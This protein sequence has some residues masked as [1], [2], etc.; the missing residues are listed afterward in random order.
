MGRAERRTFS[1][2]ELA[3]CGGLTGYEGREVPASLLRSGR[4]PMQDDHTSR[5]GGPEADGLQQPRAACDTEGG[6]LD[7]SAGPAGG[8]QQYDHRRGP[9]MR[10]FTLLTLVPTIASACSSNKA[11]DNPKPE[12]SVQ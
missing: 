12:R 4:I 2:T 7:A 5:R 1:G 8:H 9:T 6:Q 3:K 11:A 10:H